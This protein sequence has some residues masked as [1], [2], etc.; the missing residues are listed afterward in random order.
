M[1]FT[2]PLLPLLYSVSRSRGFDPE[3]IQ[4]RFLVHRKTLVQ[5]L[6]SGLRFSAVGVAPTKLD[7]QLHINNALMIRTSGRSM[8]TFKVVVIRISGSRGRRSTSTLLSCFKSLRTKAAGWKRRKLKR[9]SLRR[10][11]FSI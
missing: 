5:F 9:E 4:M 7:S 8:D 11:I 10:N 1:P 2:R 3:Q 6:L